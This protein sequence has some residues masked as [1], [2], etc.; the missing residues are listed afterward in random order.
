MTENEELLGEV[1]TGGTPPATED[2]LVLVDNS[3]RPY[4]TVQDVDTE[5]WAGVYKN[6]SSQNVNIAIDDAYTGGGG[7]LGNVDQAGAYSYIVPKTTENFYLTRV[8]LT[9]YINFFAPYIDAKVDPVFSNGVRDYVLDGG[10]NNIEE[11]V[12]L[13]FVDDATG[14]GKS[15]NEIRENAAKD[16]WKHLVSY[17]IMDKVESDAGKDNRVIIYTRS[18]S[19]VDEYQRNTRNMKLETITFWEQPIVDIDGNY[20]YVKHRWEIGQLVVLHSDPVSRWQDKTD[21][22]YKEFETISTGINVL[23]VYPMFSGY[24]AIGDYKPALPDSFKVARI[25]AMIYNL[26]NWLNYLLFKQGHGLYVFQGELDG[27][28]DALSN[29]VTIPAD[30]QDS[31]YKMPTILEPD[32][33]LPRA[34]SQNIQEVVK[35]MIAVMGNNGVTVTESNT[36]E[37]GRSKAFDFIGTNDTLLKTIRMLERADKWIKEMFN[38]FEARTLNY[39]YITKYPTEFYPDT[40][41]NALD[42]MELAKEMED[43]GMENVVKEMFKNIIAT[44]LRDVQ[45]EKLTEIMNDVDDYVIQIMDDTTGVTTTEEEEEGSNG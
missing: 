43:R 23:N 26:Q 10:D 33:E 12:W 32:P 29:I 21:I 18:A 34:H 6:F 3:N 4:N 41:L 37:S 20:I 39:Q 14:T 31:K 8:V 40:G 17:L 28:R 1:V 7:F 27:L 5:S 24:A 2:G 44:V 19:E 42:V 30:T 25:C 16:A 45:P 9:Q 35:L 13:D 15:L 38:L 36:A 22:E 11:D